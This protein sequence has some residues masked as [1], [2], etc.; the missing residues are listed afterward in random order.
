MHLLIALRFLPPPSIF[1][2]PSAFISNDLEI[3]IMLESSQ[4]TSAEAQANR[5]LARWNPT[6]L[7]RHF[8]SAEATH[9]SFIRNTT[10][11]VHFVTHNETVPDKIEVHR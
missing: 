4:K 5:L 3:F 1:V 10:P 9:S 11:L 8:L 7:R 6:L 2:P